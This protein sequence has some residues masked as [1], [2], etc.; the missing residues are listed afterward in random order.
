MNT[1][2][3][4]VMLVAVLTA[5]VAQAQFHIGMRT[6]LNVSSMYGNS[7]PV[8][9]EGAD[10]GGKLGVQIGVMGELALGRVFAIQP[11]LLFS[12]AGYTSTTEAGSVESE[13]SYNFNYLHVPLNA[14]IKLPLGRR[15][16]LFL[17]VGPYAGYA[18]NGKYKLE[19]M[20]DQKVVKTEK[21]DV[22][23][24]N[25]A[26]KRFD[27]GLGFG[28]GCQAGAVQVDLGMTVGLMNIHNVTGYDMRNYGLGLAVSYFF[29]K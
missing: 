29:G 23:F 11:G 10:A 24:G 13:M 19:D 26:L 17:S 22:R 20:E 14:L 2:F 28:L 1:K 6:G 25:D 15:A 16:N 7:V 9:A 21:S 18:I 3:L 4:T 5:N 12:M 27:A 8:I